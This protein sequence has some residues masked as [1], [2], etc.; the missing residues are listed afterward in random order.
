MSIAPVTPPDSSNAVRQRYSK[1]RAT[2]ETRTMLMT[3]TFRSKESKTSLESLNDGISELH[4]IANALK[5]V[6]DE[7]ARMSALNEGREAR[8]VGW[9]HGRG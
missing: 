1:P 3:M 9:K 2:I 4:Y 7:M 6:N 5:S 8:L